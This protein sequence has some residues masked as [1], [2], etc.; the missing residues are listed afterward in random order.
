MISKDTLVEYVPLQKATKGDIAINTQYDM[1]SLDSI[2][3]LKMDFLGLSN[4]TVIKNALRII[5]KVYD[6]DIDIYNLPMDDKKTYEL[7]SK[8]ETTGVFQFESA[9]MKRYLKDLKP[10][11][12]ED[13]IAMVALYRPRPMQFI[14]NFIACKHGRKKTHYEHPL[15]ENALKNTYGVI[16]YQ[17]QLMQVSKD[18]AGFS[19]G[20]A[21]SLRKAM[22]KKI[23]ELMKK[24]RT[25]FIDGSV[26]NGVDEKIAIKIFNDFE[27]FAQYAFNKSHSACYAL[28]AYWTAYLKVHYPSAFMAALLTSDYGNSD[29]IAIEIA[30]CQRMNI[31]VLPPDV[32][33]SF[34]EFGVVIESG[35]I[36]FG[37]SAVK[38]V[39]TGAIEAILEAR[40]KDGQF[41]S[42]EEFAKRVKASEI[43]KKV[44][45][46][47]IKC[48]AFDSLG[49]RD[50]LLFNMERI[51]NFGSKAQGHTAAGQID[52][53]GGN[54]V[55]M[56]PLK[57]EK[58]DTEVSMQT[59]LNWE[60]ELLGIYVSAHP[61]KEYQEVFIRAGVTPLA[62]LTEDNK[63]I[64]IGGV[65]SAIQ[66][67]QTRTKEPM[68]F[69]TFEDS[70]GQ[71]ELVVFP[72]II[73]DFPNVWEVGKVLLIYGK[74]NTK[75]N[76]IKVI[77]D[78]AKVLE[79]NLE[80]I[81]VK[82]TDPLISQSVRLDEK[83]EVNIFIPRG[84]SAEA[85]NDIN[86]KLAANKGEF[87]VLVYV[88]N[89]QSGPKRVRLP[90]RIS[91]TDKLADDIRKRLSKN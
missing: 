76:Q 57:L 86:V 69:V 42:I 38:N 31:E 48:G 73:K 60:R 20:D 44:M 14:D 25:K 50:L 75:D 56:P 52:L 27:N 84:T 87:P 12:F 24:M 4:L 8:G 66:R 7:L 80:D 32:N 47:L 13:V 58:P 54:G 62:S 78:R 29:R 43:N 63:N 71:T 1:G 9:G 81:D 79:G 89:G 53:F 30:E 19:G 49:G 17:E 28:I 64:C 70:T 45:E 11:V 41:K 15:L 37:L 40:E 6:K 21:D 74:V 83:G 2:G 39:G 33:E 68:N 3:L 82:I 59:K 26:K 72:K 90:F 91:Y 46:S 34:S 77:V 67:I 36:R 51:L 18:M 23:A 85:L 10:T 5:K 88:P 61:T 65:V 16:V 55:E 22:G 35:K